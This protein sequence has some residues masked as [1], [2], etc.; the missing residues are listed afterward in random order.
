MSYFLAVKFGDHP[1]RCVLLNL[2][3]IVAIAEHEEGVSITMKNGLKILSA[4]PF[5]KIL[6]GIKEAHRRMGGADRE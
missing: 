2:D 6:D 1:H 4:T 5:D 3:E